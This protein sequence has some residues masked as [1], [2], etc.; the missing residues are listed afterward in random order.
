DAL[1][2][3]GEVSISSRQINSKVQVTVSDD[4]TG[5]PPEIVETI[6]EP[7]F[8]TKGVQGTGLG[9]AISKK[10]INDHGGEIR[11]K[12]TVGHGAAFIIELPIY[13]GGENCSGVADHSPSKNIKAN[14]LIVENLPDIQSMLQ[15]TLTT[16][17]YRVAVATN[18]EEAMMQ[19]GREKFDLMIIGF[20]LPGIGGLELV[21]QIRNFDKKTRIILTSSWEIDHS[22]SELISKGVDSIITKPFTMEMILETLENLLSSERVTP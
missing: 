14:I 4:G 1:P 17:G 10:V 15:A 21:S 7:F 16:Y 19:C 8:T 18:G 9:L 3:G 12:S 6:F 20:S 11:V 22:I 5:I 13:E 2:K